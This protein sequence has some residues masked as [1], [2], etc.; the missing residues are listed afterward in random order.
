METSPSFNAARAH[1]KLDGRAGLRAAGQSE[2]LVDHGQH[3]SAGRLDR[4][5]RAVH[6]SECIDSG[7]PNDG[8]FACSDVTGGNVFGERTHVEAFVIPTTAS[9][10]NRSG[11]N[12]AAA[13]QVVQASPRVLALTDLWLGFFRRM[14]TNVRRPAHAR[15]RQTGEEG[16]NQTK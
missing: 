3:A 15:Q 16:Q 9:R 2:F 14:G 1:G 6:I 10:R 4:D 7:L 5:D 13:R 11:G 12:A 8:I